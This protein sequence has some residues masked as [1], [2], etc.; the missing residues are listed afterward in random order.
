MKHSVGE[1]VRIMKLEN[2]NV[3]TVGVIL[4]G[5]QVRHI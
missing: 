3:G 4:I 5:V 1:N 2:G